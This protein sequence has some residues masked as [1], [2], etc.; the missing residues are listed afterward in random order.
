MFFSALRKAGSP[1]SR[2]QLSGGREASTARVRVARN[3]D[4]K[5]L[6]IGQ[7]QKAGEDQQIGREEAVGGRALRMS[8]ASVMPR[9]TAGSRPGRAARPAPP[10]GLLRDRQA[11]RRAAICLAASSS[12]ALASG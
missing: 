6:M 12:A 1:I 7:T 9:L 10:S 4:Q 11:G 5:E 3:E 8:A 2:P